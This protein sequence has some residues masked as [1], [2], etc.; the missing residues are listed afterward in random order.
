MGTQAGTQGV[1]A[2][3]AA[4]N[5]AFGDPDDGTIGQAAAQAQPAASGQQDAGQTARVEDGQQAGGNTRAELPEDPVER[6]KVLE[7]RLQ[8]FEREKE[9]LKHQVRSAT[10]RIGAMQRELDS[11]R[12]SKPQAAAPAQATPAPAASPR[13]EKVEALREE[14]PDVVSALEELVSAR[15]APPQSVAH[16]SQPN[17]QEVSTSTAGGSEEAAL[18]DAFPDWEQT[19]MTNEFDQFLKSRGADYERRIKGTDRPSEMMA[20][21][22]QFERTKAHSATRTDPGQQGQNTAVNQARASRVS[23]AVQP[24]QSA[25][26]TAGRAAPMSAEEAF[27]QGFTN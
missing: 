3:L 25:P 10:G 15:V 26:R 16:D 6:L 12:G 27:R 21:I 23:Q 11:R 24:N 22:A 8:A 13:L 7:E 9:D 19:V 1:D 17:G 2:G 18:Y 4:F 20:A 14:L 5:A